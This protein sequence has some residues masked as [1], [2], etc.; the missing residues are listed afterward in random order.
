MPE[1]TSDNAIVLSTKTL[2][3]NTYILSLF[4]AE[5]GRH[6]GVIKKK[7]PPQI[8][9]L[10]HATWKARLPEQLGSFY[11]EEQQAYAPLYLDDMPR[12][13]TLS[14]ICALLDK[15]LPER[16]TYLTLHDYT[17]KLLQNLSSHDF[18]KHY[19]LFEI[20]LLAHLGFGL[21]TSS[22][23]GG[24]NATDLAYISPKTGRAVSREKGAPYHDKLLIL[25]KFI[26]QDCPA[27]PKD[28]IDG[29]KLTEHFLTNC[30]S[31]DIIP[32]IRT[33]LIKSIKDE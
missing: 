16:Q 2:G 4:T 10:L 28:L 7:H 13:N 19:I 20:S 31:G 12:L 8:G 17:L 1:W 18:L 24:G 21:D 33:R 22:C 32:A 11:I 3:E 5:H 26:W 30:L 9:T 25:P 23:A 29:F 6:L 15:A 14:C 27:L